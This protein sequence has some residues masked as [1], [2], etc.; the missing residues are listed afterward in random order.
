M[1]YWL[2]SEAIKMNITPFLQARKMTA[3]VFILFLHSISFPATP[4]D[5][6][7]IYINGPSISKHFDPYYHDYRDFHPGL[8]GEFYYQKKKWI[9]G[10]NGHY[11]FKDSSDQKAYWFGLVNG[12]SIGNKKKLWL[13]P[14]ILIGGIKK[15]EYNSGNFGFFAM[16]FLSMGYNCVGFNIAFI[17]KLTNITYPVLLVQIKIKVFQF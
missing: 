10:F 14:F 1:I 16:P 2:F 3:T 11:M 5:K 6:F 13:E 4:T 7:S 17:P 12:I 15:A 8:G 9:I